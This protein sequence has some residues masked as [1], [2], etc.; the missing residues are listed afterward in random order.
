M[1]SAVDSC[2]CIIVFSM[3]I[4]L[5]CVLILFPCVFAVQ[6]EANSVS[7]TVQG[8]VPANGTEPPLKHGLKTICSNLCCLSHLPCSIFLLTSVRTQNHLQCRRREL[9]LDSWLLD[10]GD[11]TSNSKSTPVQFGSSSWCAA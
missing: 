10:P 7:R 4:L 8:I 11:V 1:F 2:D 3:F 5:L 6:I 9:I